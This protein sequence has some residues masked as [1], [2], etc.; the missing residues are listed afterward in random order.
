MKKNI[1]F[2]FP[3]HGQCD[4]SNLYKLLHYYKSLFKKGNS[5]NHTLLLPIYL[6]NLLEKIYKNLIC[7]HFLIILIKDIYQR[8]QDF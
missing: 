3:P 6:Q 5:Y 8:S 2:H 4:P 7:S 1:Y